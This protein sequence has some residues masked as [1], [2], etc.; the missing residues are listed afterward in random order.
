MQALIGDGRHVSGEE[1]GILEFCMDY[2]ADGYTCHV[3]KMVV[4][5]FYVLFQNWHPFLDAQV[6]PRDPETSR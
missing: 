5:I 1:D 6:S 4:M 3:D 2:Y